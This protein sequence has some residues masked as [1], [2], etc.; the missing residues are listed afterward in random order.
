[1]PRINKVSIYICY[2]IKISNSINVLKSRKDG[3]GKPSLW[4]EFLQNR[5]LPGPNLS[6]QLT[7]FLPWGAASDLDDIFWCYQ[8]DPAQ[9]TMAEKKMPIRMPAADKA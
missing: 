6:I 3:C 4:G 1:M 7:A 8:Y 2:G 5:T 9:N